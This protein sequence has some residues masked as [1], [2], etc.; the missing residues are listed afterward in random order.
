MK[1]LAPYRIKGIC[2]PEGWATWL[3]GL[4]KGYKV[5]SWIG[6]K[7]S[8]E[9][10]I[11]SA[12]YQDTADRCKSSF[13]SWGETNPESGQVSITSRGN[14]TLLSAKKGFDPDMIRV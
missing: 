7:W 2:W 8:E 13:K 4:S 5:K 1:A 14:R 12:V 11:S 3:K 10:L 9:H 6:M